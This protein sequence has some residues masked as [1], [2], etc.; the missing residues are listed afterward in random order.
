MPI[1]LEDTYADILGKAQRGLALTDEDLSRDSGLSLGKINELKAGTVDLL[2]LNALAPILKLKTDALI[3]LAQNRWNPAPVQLIDLVQFNTPFSDMRV[4]S[5]LVADFD[6]RLAIAFDTGT[7]ATHMLDYLKKQGLK[8]ELILLTHTHGDHILELDRLKEKTGAHA[9]VSER[10]PLEG[11][12]SFPAGKTFQIGS[13]SIESRLTWGHSP[14]GISYVVQGLAQP[15]A[16]VGDALF[17][18]SMGG[19]KESYSAAL[20]TNRKELFTLPDDTILC[21]G[22]GPMTT[23][24][25]QKK[26]NPFFPEFV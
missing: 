26:H 8:L 1:P 10:E 7:D 20:E 22:H 25:E 15:V 3:E 13:L 19:G 6:N 9:F 21:P 11:A 12:E 17:A 5:Y 24:A 16:I 2:A 4:N 18:C 14:G 23:L